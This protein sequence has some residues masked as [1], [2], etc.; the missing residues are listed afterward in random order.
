MAVKVFQKMCTSVR[1]G[2][3]FFLGKSKRSTNVIFFIRVRIEK[4]VSEVRKKWK[5]NFG[6]LDFGEKMANSLKKMC[7]RVRGV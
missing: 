1:G 5:T 3:F 2:N 6:N 7:N 4:Q